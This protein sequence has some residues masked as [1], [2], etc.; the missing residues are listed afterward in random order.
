MTGPPVRRPPRWVVVADDFAGVLSSQ[1]KLTAHPVFCLST[2]VHRVGFGFL[3]GAEL[4]VKE[5]ASKPP[6][7]PILP[8][9][10]VVDPFV[11]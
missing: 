7:R 4:T 8:L 5:V 9:L 6:N 3:A 2:D 1:P 11:V 10:S